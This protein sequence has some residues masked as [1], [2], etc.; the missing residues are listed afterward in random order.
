MKSWIL[1]AL[2][3]AGMVVDAGAADLVLIRD[4]KN[5]IKADA[6]S[7]TKINESKP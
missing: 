1:M 7:K 6:K 2:G 5:H 4:G 3:M